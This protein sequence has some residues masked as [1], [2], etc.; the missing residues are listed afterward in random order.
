MP[1]HISG[2]TWGIKAHRQLCTPTHWL[3]GKS[4]WLLKPLILLWC[5]CNE[6]VE[7]IVLCC[8]FVPIPCCFVSIY[9]LCCTW[10]LCL[11]IITI[12]Y[13]HALVLTVYVDYYCIS[14]L[15]CTTML[16]AWPTFWGIGWYSRNRVCVL[17]L[18]CDMIVS[19]IGQLVHGLFL[20]CICVIL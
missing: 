11:I 19:V 16:G 3:N 6:L 4:Y 15:L 1:V 14:L 13:G 12:L 5:G 7:P 2:P 10:L 9:Y 18:C 20:D 17:S 8:Y